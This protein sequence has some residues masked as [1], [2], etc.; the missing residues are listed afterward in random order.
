MREN[1]TYG[2]EGGEAKSLPY[3][4]RSDHA[5]RLLRL[6]SAPCQEPLRFQEVG[7]SLR[8]ELTDGAQPILD[9]GGADHLAAFERVNVDRHQLERLAAMRRAHE[10]ARRCAGGFAAHRDL[11]ARDQDLLDFPFQVR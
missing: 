2:S 10:F 4:Y 3:P 1:R 5:H 6:R 9:M 8:R 7:G 11:V